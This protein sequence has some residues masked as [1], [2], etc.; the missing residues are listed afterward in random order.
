MTPQPPCQRH[1]R[2]GRP[3]MQAGLYRPAD[4]QLSCWRHLTR[5]ERQAVQGRS[6]A[7]LAAS[8]EQY[9]SEGNRYLSW[10]VPAR[11]AGQTDLD[12]LLAF[13]SG[14][15]AWCGRGDESLAQDHDH[16]TELLRGLLCDG[17]NK[18]EAVYGRSIKRPEISRPHAWDLYRRIP[19]AVLLDL[20]VRFPNDPR[21]RCGCQG[22][23]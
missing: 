23:V 4:E 5:E 14:R 7:A 11:R 16:E 18:A 17:C 21:C 8:T 22:V 13:Q 1:Y 10:A 2:N 12:Y 20:N 9:M 19:P 15:C 3:C 6:S